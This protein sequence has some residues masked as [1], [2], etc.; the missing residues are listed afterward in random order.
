M[1]IQNVTFNAEYNII[2][3]S[4]DGY[5][6]IREPWDLKKIIKDNLLITK[7]CTY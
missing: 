3:A 4:A 6:N 7:N 1:F 2:I 5:K